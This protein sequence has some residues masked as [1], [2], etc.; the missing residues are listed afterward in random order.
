MWYNLRQ[1]LSHNCLFN[2]IV[3]NRGSGKT[4]SFKEWAIDDFIKSGKQFIYLRRYQSELDAVKQSLFND[5]ASN[6]KYSHLKITIEGDNF[7]IDGELAGFAMALSRATTFKSS[8]YPL[9]N[10]ICYDEFIIEGGKVGYLKNE[11]RNFLDFY[12]TIARMRE[13]I[14]FFLSNA[15]TMY[16][17]Y[18]LYFDLQLPY[19]KL[20]AK[21]N[22]V[23]LELVQNPEYIQAKKQTRFGRLIEGT[24]YADYAIENAFLLDN[25]S[26][27][28]RKG[29]SAHYYF[30]FIYEGKNYGVWVDNK[31]GK[32]YV[33][34]DVDT[35]CCV[36]FSLTLD[37][38]TPNTMFLKAKR[39]QTMFKIFLE[40]FEIGN[41]R[42]ENKLIKRM[43]LDIIKS[44]M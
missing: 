5:I 9:V 42:F 25:N 14:V 4:Y 7:Y 10:K 33:S 22:D 21:K 37:D 2:F 19:G 16:N 34:E 31:V 17:P 32:M 27:I 26:F 29:K 18:T 36:C 43:C 15:I 39:K 44:T 3:G 38:H 11:V 6:D 40:Q 12:E 8:S 41:V 30:T 13:V 20:V 35:S 23:L 28:E 1:T 24:E